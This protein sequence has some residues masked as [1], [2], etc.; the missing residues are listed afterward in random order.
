[1]W[2]SLCSDGKYFYSISLGYVLKGIH[3]TDTSP[4]LSRIC[5]D[6]IAQSRCNSLTV[7]APYCVGW[8]WHMGKVTR[9]GVDGGLFL[10]SS[11]DVPFSHLL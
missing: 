6:G 9:V 11:G 8:M 3:F 2:T 5:Y 4:R 10:S 7:L 1:M